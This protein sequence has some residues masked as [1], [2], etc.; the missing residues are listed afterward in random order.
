MEKDCF[1]EFYN[2]IRSPHTNKI[3]KHLFA[4]VFCII[5]FGGVILL[6]SAFKSLGA[7]FFYPDSRIVNMPAVCKICI[8]TS[9]MGICWAYLSSFFDRT[10]WK[11]VNIKSICYS[12]PKALKTYIDNAQ[13]QAFFYLLTLGSIVA[14]HAIV[15][16]LIYKNLNFLNTANILVEYKYVALFLLS[17]L[18][19]ISFILWRVGVIYKMSMIKLAFPEKNIYEDWD[20]IQKIIKDR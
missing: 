15:I 17:L 20:K 8:S 19:E 7:D 3:Y 1:I 6:Y 14:L 18:A 11:I 12:T 9:I 4:I 10:S 5:L 16:A 13:T 2:F